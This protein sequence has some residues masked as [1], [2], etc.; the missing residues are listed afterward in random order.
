MPAVS[1]VGDADNGKGIILQ[2]ASTVFVNGRPVGIKGKKVSP[3][4][5]GPHGPPCVVR[6]GSGTVFAEGTPVTYVG[7]QDSCGHVRAKGSSDVFVGT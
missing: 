6:Q 5:K 7:A 4:G 1:R 3:H 2:G